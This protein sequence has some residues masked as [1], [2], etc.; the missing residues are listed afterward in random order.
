MLKHSGHSNKGFAL[1]ELLVVVAVIMIVAAIAIPNLLR[2][3]GAANS[4]SAV[5]TLKTINT[6]EQM[7]FTSCA[8]YAP[9]LLALGPPSTA[10]ATPGCTDAAPADL[11]DA[12]V[13]G[14]SA[15]NAKSNYILTYAAGTANGSYTILADP[16]TSI[17]LNPNH[18]FTDQSG[19][20][21]LSVG[22]A[23]GVTST[24]I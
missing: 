20:I 14:L 15:T 2:A 10:G 3:K 8:T 13:A 18:Y 4:T 6:A 11:V 9:D 5:S 23:A 7:Y 19:V 24:P 21:R 12:V 1:I 22:S 17:P 16:D